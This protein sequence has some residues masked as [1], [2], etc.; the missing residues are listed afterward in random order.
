VSP[1]IDT[2]PYRYER[3]DERVLTPFKERESDQNKDG[4]TKGF[5][6]SHIVGTYSSEVVETVRNLTQPRRRR[7]GVTRG[8]LRTGMARKALDSTKVAGVVIGGG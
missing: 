5:G 8:R 3:G 1:H 6:E 4:S 2:G 7:P